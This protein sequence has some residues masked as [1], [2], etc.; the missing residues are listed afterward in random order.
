MPDVDDFAERWCAERGIAYEPTFKPR[1][2][3]KD[4]DMR[5]F[6]LLA[7]LSDDVLSAAIERAHADN[8][9]AQ[10]VAAICRRGRPSGFESTYRWS[11]RRSSS[12]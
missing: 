8:K 5:M 10:Y 4:A 2:K 11:S 7:Q 12:S 9:V 1:K 6:E 3:R